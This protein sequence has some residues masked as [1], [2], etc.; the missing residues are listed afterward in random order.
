MVLGFADGRLNPLGWEA[1]GVDIA[2]FQGG[3]HDFQ[4]VILI[5]NGKA[6]IKSKSIRVAP[7]QVD[8]EAMKRADAQ[9]AMRRQGH[10]GGIKFGAVGQELPDALAHLAGG[11]VGESHGQNVGRPDSMLQEQIEDAAGDDAGFAAARPGDHEQ[12]ALEMRDGLLL[13]R[14][15]IGE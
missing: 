9:E 14:C 13:G 12:G 5:V 2:G 7:H 6:R 10:A 15:Q 11:L 4:P 1:V 8:A 3:L